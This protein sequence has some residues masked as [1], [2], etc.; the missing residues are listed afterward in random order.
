MREQ[1]GGAI[2]NIS[3]LAAVGGG[4]Q[5]AYEVSKAGVNR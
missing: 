2:V 4:I 1:S 3:S 5:L